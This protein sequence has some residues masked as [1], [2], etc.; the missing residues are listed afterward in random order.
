MV[1]GKKETQTT[2]TINTGETLSNLIDRLIITIVQAQPIK[3]KS[4][5]LNETYFKSSYYNDICGA[6]HGMPREWVHSDY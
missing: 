3:K 5:S 2:Q 1:G 4:N 6:F